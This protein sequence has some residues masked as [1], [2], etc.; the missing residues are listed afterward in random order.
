VRAIDFDDCGFGPLLY[1]HAVMLSAVLGWP[2]YDDMREGLLGGYS[3]LRPLPTGYEWL[4]DLFI[5]LRQVQDGL[6]A[7]EYRVHPAL[8]EDWAAEARQSLAPLPELLK[9]SDSASG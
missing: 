2:E 7:L 4:L 8:G 3:P 6:W 9:S 1:D 5:A